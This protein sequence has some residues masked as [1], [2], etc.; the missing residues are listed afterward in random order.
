MMDDYSVSSDGV[1]RPYDHP[2][3]LNMLVHDCTLLP[4]SACLLWGFSSRRNQ[5]KHYL[6]RIATYKIERRKRQQT[7]FFF[8]LF[9]TQQ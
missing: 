4:T 9:F 2:S 6:A 1:T 8:F 3:H 7:L 5:T